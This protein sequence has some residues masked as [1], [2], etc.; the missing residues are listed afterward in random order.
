MAF[1]EAE[2]ET[3]AM[4]EI[5]HGNKKGA[6]I[7]L[8]SQTPTPTGLS[9]IHHGYRTITIDMS[10]T[11][12]SILCDEKPLRSSDWSKIKFNKDGT[13]EVSLVSCSTCE[14]REWLTNMKLT[15]GLEFSVWI[16]AEFEWKAR[17]P[18]S[19]E[20][21]VDLSNLGGSRKNPQLV[22]QFEIDLT[23]T[24]RRIPPANGPDKQKWKINEDRLTD[25]AFR[26][27]TYTVRLDKGNFLTTYDSNYIK[28]PDWVPRYAL[29][30]TFE[31]SPYPPRHEWKEDVCG[32]DTLKFWDYKE[33]C[34]R[35]SPELKR[36]AAGYALW[37]NCII[38]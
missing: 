5:R 38:C 27:K 30:L 9:T 19:L 28:E 23:L 3:E 17:N 6:N 8:E 14:E 37:E 29:R 13:G 7:L 15:L 32:V 26:P 36:Q 21:V 4:T 18:E 34:A 10:E 2:K 22:S 1:A 20:Q 12:L 16:L 35:A 11:L 33:F 31:P 24:K 25:D